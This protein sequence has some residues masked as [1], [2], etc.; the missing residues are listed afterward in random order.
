MSMSDMV[1]Y[2]FALK[3]VFWLWEKK[4]TSYIGQDEPLVIFKKNEEPKKAHF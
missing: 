2:M 3:D 1:F 4:V